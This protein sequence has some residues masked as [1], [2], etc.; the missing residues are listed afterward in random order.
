[1]ITTKI[2]QYKLKIPAALCRVQQALCKV[3][4]IT[5]VKNH[6]GLYCP[7]VVPPGLAQVYK[8]EEKQ[9]LYGLPSDR[10]LTVPHVFTLY[11]CKHANLCV[12][13]C[14]YFYHHGGSQAH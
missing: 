13:V 6:C 4:Q 9:N 8:A 7:L 5:E 3:T 1:M 12:C 2:L 10:N 11:L 14:T